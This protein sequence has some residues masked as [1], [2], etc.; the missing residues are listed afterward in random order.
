[1]LKA[2]DVAVKK[3][4]EVFSNKI[5]VYGLQN[6]DSNDFESAV[7][8][9]GKNT[10]E[11]K[12]PFPMISVFRTPDIQITDSSQTKRASTADGFTWADDNG[13]ALSL[14][15]MRSTLTYTIDVF[16]VTRESAEKIAIMLFFRLRN[17]PEISVDF[18][19]GKE[20][21]ENCKAEIEL[22]DSITNMRVN[23]QTKAQAY[24]IRFSFKLVNANIYDLL[25]RDFPEEIKYS[26]FVELEDRE[27][28]ED[29]SESFSLEINS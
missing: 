8:Q 28:L 9:A 17:N 15:T 20:I 26:V 29:D 24:K 5:P 12:I 27:E 11:D 4:I 3:L 14:V 2:Y 7:T 18:Y 19:F 22:Q 23:D 1:M 13:K 25:V 21:F 10:G 6:D 16:D